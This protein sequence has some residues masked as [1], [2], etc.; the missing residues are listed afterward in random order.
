LLYYINNDEIEQEDSEDFYNDGFGAYESQEAQEG[1]EEQQQDR[2]E[3]EQDSLP[4]EQH[5]LNSGDAP[6]DSQERGESADTVFNGNL[7][8]NFWFQ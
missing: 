8:L 3:Q 5:T 4:R 1:E 6:D 7:T 2:S